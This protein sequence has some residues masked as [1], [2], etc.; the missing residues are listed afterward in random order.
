MDAF[1]FH[2]VL[3]LDNWLSPV[4][5]LDTCKVLVVGLLPLVGSDA[6][7]E[8]VWPNCIWYGLLLCGKPHN[9][10]LIRLL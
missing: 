9:L 10:Y 6:G 3:L 1:A 2:N 4:M 5:G 7:I 8:R